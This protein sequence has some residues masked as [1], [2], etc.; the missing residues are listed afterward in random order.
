[1]FPKFTKASTALTSQS[2]KE[3]FTKKILILVVQKTVSSIRF[4]STAFIHTIEIIQ[5]FPFRYFSI[6]NT[7]FIGSF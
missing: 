5:Y 6:K 4:E 3:H 2:S 7:V 1:M